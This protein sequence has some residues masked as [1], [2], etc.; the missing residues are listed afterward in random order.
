MDKATLLA[1]LDHGTHQ[2]ESE[3]GMDNVKLRCYVNQ[4]LSELGLG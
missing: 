4:Y 1:R 3:Q 2:K